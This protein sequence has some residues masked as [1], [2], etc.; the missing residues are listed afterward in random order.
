MKLKDAPR[1][2][3]LWLAVVRLVISIA[4]IPLAPFLY[5]EHF[6]LLVLMRPTKEVLL[7]AGFLIRAGKV[8]LLPVLLAAVPLM[9][10]GVWLF[11]YLGRAYS[12]DIV[13]GEVPGIGGR[14][15]KADKVKE[16]GKLLDKQGSRLVFLGRLA[17]F[18]SAVVAA[19]AG[20]FKQRPREF[21]PADGLGALV[22]ISVAI[23]AGYFLG[24]AYEDASPVLSVIGVAVLVGAAVLLGRYLKK[25]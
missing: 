8:D 7:A 2:V 20:A 10:L 12:K 9:V 22:S 19:A 1:V 14:L 3:L 6:I 5:R 25:N 4:A 17:A 11:F 24:E 18:P 13:K 23:A 15:L 21:L 16:M